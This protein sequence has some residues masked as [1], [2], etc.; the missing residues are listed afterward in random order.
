MPAECPPRFTS[1]IWRISL[2]IAAGLLL[3]G[4]NLPAA[5]PTMTSTPSP[6]LQ[7][8]V[9]QTFAAMTVQAVL[10]PPAATPTLPPLPTDTP[11]PATGSISG[12]LSYPS[13]FIPPLRIVAFRVDGSGY[14]YVDTLE[15]QTTYQI[16][17]LTPGTYHVVAYT[18]DGAL[19]GGYTQMVLCGLRVECTDHTLIGV[20]VVPGQDTPNIDP[21]D[22]Y[23]PPGTFPP[24]PQP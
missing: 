9:L 11:V 21:A 7:A 17:G 12:T 14:R 13:Q 20:E 8:I 1:V 22:W 23:A 4:C 19:A 2:A 18:R 24:M 6:D 16:S 10:T 15:N 5:G 3:V